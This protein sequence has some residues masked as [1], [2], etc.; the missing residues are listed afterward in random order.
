M[1]HFHSLHTNNYVPLSFSLS[2]V[3]FDF[4][5]DGDVLLFHS[6]ANVCGCSEYTY[7]F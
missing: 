7:S 3:Q 1:V 2:R 4:L 5:N 6:T